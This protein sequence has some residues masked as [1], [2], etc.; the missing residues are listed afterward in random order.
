MSHIQLFL[1]YFLSSSVL[2][3]SKQSPLSPAVVTDYTV[4]V[5]MYQIVLSLFF[6]HSWWRNFRS[7]VHVVDAFC[8]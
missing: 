2:I 3:N 1:L 6:L 8:L 5:R 7:F 4:V